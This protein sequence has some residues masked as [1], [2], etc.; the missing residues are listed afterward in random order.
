ML[1]MLLTTCICQIPTLLALEKLIH[2]LKISD[3]EIEE[4]RHHS[5]RD[6]R[7]VHKM[8]LMVKCKRGAGPDAATSA[9][10]PV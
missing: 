6:P 1:P 8:F 2:G 5:N 4:A 3:I 10:S 7:L 9:E